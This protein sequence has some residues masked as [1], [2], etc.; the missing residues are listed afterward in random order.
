MDKKDISRRLFSG[1]LLA[2]GAVLLSACGTTRRISPARNT[3]RRGTGAQDEAV[4]LNH[5]AREFLIAAA[6]PV[7]DAAGLE[8]MDIEVNNITL[9]QTIETRDENGNLIQ[10][11]KPRLNIYIS[12]HTS[13]NASVRDDSFDMYINLGLL[14]EAR[15][16]EAIQFVIAHE[17]GHIVSEDVR[18]LRSRVQTA[19]MRSMI[20]SAATIAGAI[21]GSQV[22]PDNAGIIGRAAQTGIAIGNTAEGR[23][24]TNFIMQREL[25]ADRYAIGLMKRAGIALAGARD[26]LLCMAYQNKGRGSG[27]PYGRTH[28]VTENRINTVEDSMSNR[29]PNDRLNSLLRTMQ[30][31]IDPDHQYAYCSDQPGGAPDPRIRSRRDLFHPRR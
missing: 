31:S 17:L 23:G 3:H 27:S 21:I 16:A 22:S 20:T 13:L 28:P 25:A 4:F 19:Q 2:A 5:E 9:P 29:R 8:D 11:K 14:K 10:T 24:L 18:E 6:R 15:S 7:L 26:L 30:N 12:P 1:G